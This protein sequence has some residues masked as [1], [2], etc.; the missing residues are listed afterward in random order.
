MRSPFTR[1][2]ALSAAA[3]AQWTNAYAQ[4][5]AVQADET[6]TQHEVDD[7][8][9]LFDAVPRSATMYGD[10]NCDGAVDSADAACILRYTVKLQELSE[11]GA[12]NADVDGAAKVTTADAACILR[13]TV[14]I[15]L[16]FPVEEQ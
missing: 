2:A 4:A 6:H 15:I 1:R 16:V 5:T 13:Q 8:A 11:Q 9:A 10:A 7:A 14:K 3:Q 12:I